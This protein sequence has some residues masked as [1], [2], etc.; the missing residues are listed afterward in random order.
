MTKLN[1][2][3]FLCFIF[4]CPLSMQPNWGQP[5]LWKDTWLYSELDKYY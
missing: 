2:S 3:F 5:I 1:S 4:S